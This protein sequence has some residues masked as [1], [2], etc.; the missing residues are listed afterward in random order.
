MASFIAVYSKGVFPILL[1]V[2]F[3]YDLIHEHCYCIPLYPD[4]IISNITPDSPPAFLASSHQTALLLS[5]LHL[6][7]DSCHRNLCNEY[8][9]TFITTRTFSDYIFS[10]NLISVFFCIRLGLLLSIVKNTACNLLGYFRLF[11]P[12]S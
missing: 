3:I 7:G 12:F 11:L 1:N 6:M 8:C 10:E 2:L 9:R 5:L 4:S